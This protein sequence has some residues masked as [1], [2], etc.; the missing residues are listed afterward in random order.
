MPPESFHLK[1]QQDNPAIHVSI[2]WILL[3]LMQRFRL[4][5]SPIAT[6]CHMAH[7]VKTSSP[8]VT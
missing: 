2:C 8:T 5:C 4:L 3:E 6:W 1:L 7:Y